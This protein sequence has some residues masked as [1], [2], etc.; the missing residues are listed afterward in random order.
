[1]N[2]TRTEKELGCLEAKFEDSKMHIENC[3]IENVDLIIE[4]EDITG[5]SVIFILGYW[6]GL[7]YRM[8]N[9]SMRIW[10]I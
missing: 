1:M 2:E 4:R 7:L 6:R 8:K 5:Y 9:T 3:V 10:S